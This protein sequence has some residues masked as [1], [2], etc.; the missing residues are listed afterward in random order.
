MNITLVLRA[1]SGLPYTPVPS[2]E[3]NDLLVEKNSGRMPSVQRVDLRISRM[4]SIADMRYTIFA[5]VNNVFDKLNAVNVWDTSGNA[6]DAGPTYS[7]TRDRMKNPQY[8]DVRRSIQMG[9]R[10]DF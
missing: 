4:F 7:R 9:V 6:W 8:M 1:S 5:I 2:E 10:L 3:A